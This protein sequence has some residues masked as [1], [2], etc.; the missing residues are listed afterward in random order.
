MPQQARK[1]RAC[2][3]HIWKPGRKVKLGDRVGCGNA[4]I[5]RYCRIEMTGRM[6]AMSM[7]AAMNF[8]QCDANRSPVV[9]D[10]AM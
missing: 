6:R 8:H 5:S 1:S 3:R 2:E 4:R 7:R 10:A 9:Y